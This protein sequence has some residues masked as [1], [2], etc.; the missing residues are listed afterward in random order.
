MFH[1]VYQNLIFFYCTF[2]LIPS[3]FLRQSIILCQSNLTPKILAKYAPVSLYYAKM[4]LPMY[5]LILKNNLKMPYWPQNTSQNLHH[6]HL[7]HML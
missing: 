2:Q 7:G 4:G 6:H 1:V 5:L 3:V